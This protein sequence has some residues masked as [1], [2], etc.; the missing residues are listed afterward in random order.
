MIFT[1][2][3]EFSIKKAEVSVLRFFIDCFI[4]LY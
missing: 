1:P 3:I 4:S 2:K